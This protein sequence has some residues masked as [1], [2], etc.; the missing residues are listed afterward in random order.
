M[1]PLILW[2]SVIVR[3][4]PVS[5]KVLFLALCLKKLW[6]LPMVTASMVDYPG[7]RRFKSCPRYHHR[8]GPVRGRVFCFT[9]MFH[10]VNVLTYTTLGAIVLAVRH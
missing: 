3:A 10:G 9:P 1:G 8:P 2:Y 5:L 4:T 6:V 7:G